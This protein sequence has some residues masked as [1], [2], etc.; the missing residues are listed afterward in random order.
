MN[1]QSIPK[2][3][4]AGEMLRMAREFLER[5]GVEEWRLEA[6]L[7]VAHALGLERLQLFMQIDRPVADVEIDRARDLLVRRGRREPLA[8]I[9]GKREF[10]GRSFKVG[11]G[12]LIPRPE[13]EH[14]IDR[15]RE[16]VKTWRASDA[17]RLLNIADIG[18]GSGCLAITL[19]LD[20]L[21]NEVLAIDISAAAILCAE[22]NAKALGASVHFVEGDGIVELERAASAKRFDLVVSNPPYVTPEERASL[23]PEVRE[24]EPALALFAPSGAADH[25]VE[26]LVASAERVLA[27]DGVLLI[28]LGAQQ[29]ARALAIARKSGFQARAIKDYAGIERVLE[30]TRAP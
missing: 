16:L 10:Y 15:A 1:A 11:P 19:A 24:H 13:T 4:T 3:R 2:P 8:Y 18:T 6:E 21:P 12:V 20:T 25:W 27:A 29:A 5:R 9:T 7:L 30:V 14:L 22:E 28:E 17:A 26:R 23:A